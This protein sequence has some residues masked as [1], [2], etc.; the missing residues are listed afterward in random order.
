M[1]SHLHSSADEPLAP[2]VGIAGSARIT[3]Y[4]NDM[5]VTGASSDIWGTADAFNYRHFG[6]VDDGQL[7]MKILGFSNTDSF[8]KVES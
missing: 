2:C 6:L 1:G 7:T 8:A 3:D 4:A 5:L